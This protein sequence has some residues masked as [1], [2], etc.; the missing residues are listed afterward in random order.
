[1]LKVVAYKAAGEEPAFGTD[2]ISRILRPNP[3]LFQD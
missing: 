1:M 3:R 2:E